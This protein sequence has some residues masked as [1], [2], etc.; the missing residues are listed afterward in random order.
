MPYQQNTCCEQNS[1]THTKKIRNIKNDFEYYWERTL[2]LN[3]LIGFL[4]ECSSEI[5]A[6]FFSEYYFEYC[7]FCRF[8]SGKY[9]SVWN[10]LKMV[11][12]C[13]VKCMMLDE[14]LYIYLKHWIKTS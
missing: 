5:I 4:S 1:F 2:I 10:N 13:N 7:V 14:I 11:H 9:V 8:L 3:F 12:A 6:E